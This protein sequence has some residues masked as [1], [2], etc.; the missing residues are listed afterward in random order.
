MRDRMWDVFQQ[1]ADNYYSIRR[2]YNKFI[3]DKAK[4]TM[5]ERDFSAPYIIAAHPKVLENLKQM[6]R[7]KK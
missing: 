7:E 5:M 6:E 1:R 4:L 3:I 2:A